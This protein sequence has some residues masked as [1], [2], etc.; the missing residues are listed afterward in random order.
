[1]KVLIKVGGSL[2]D[3]RDSQNRVAAQ[4]AEVTRDHQ[5]VVVHGGGHQLTRFLEAQG[6]SSAFVNGMRVSD[7]AVV[8]GVTKVIAGSVNK[9]LVAALIA[10]RATPVGISGVD[11]LLTRAVQLAPEMEFVGRPVKTESRL[12]D[13]LIQANYL[14]VIACLAVDSK[15]TIFN[16]NADQMAVSCAAGWRADK[17][18]F[19]TDVP[20]VKNASG[21][22][23]SVL[24]TVQM[25]DLID[26]GIAYGGM[27][28][29]LEA[30][31]LALASGIEEVVIAS[32]SEARVCER[33]LA[34]ECIGTRLCTIAE[35][36]VRT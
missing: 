20:G 10:A 29:K 4:I 15:G 23:A 9:S 6:V 24:N 35:T 34:G 13:L 31:G 27:Q 22:I 32:G 25:R 21:E 5:I 36:A 3:Q 16:V 12:L 2:L 28:A 18:I 7:A 17:L 33:L 19:L 26:A 14:P 8:D 30:A 11:G 1:M